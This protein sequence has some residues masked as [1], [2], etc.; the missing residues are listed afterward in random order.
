[1]ID[2]G[3][4]GIDEQ[5]MRRFLGVLPDLD[6]LGIFPER[7]TLELRTRHSHEHFLFHVN[8]KRGVIRPVMAEDSRKTLVSLPLSH[9]VRLV[10]L[11]KLEHWQEAL[12]SG[13]MRVE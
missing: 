13:T 7:F 1:M 3:D 12:H 2:A 4:S 5:L 11:G 6:P 8:R 9:F 10:E